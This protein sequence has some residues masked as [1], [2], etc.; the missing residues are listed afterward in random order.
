MTTLKQHLQRYLENYLELAKRRSQR[1]IRNY[2][3]YIER[4][5]KMS[6]LEDPAD[7]TMEAV[8]R[9]R[10]DLN[11]L[12][13]GHGRPLKASTQNYHLIAL[14][15]FL[16]YLSKND[17]KTLA[18][19]KIELARTTD[20]TVEFL[21]E[22]ELARL[23]AAPFAGAPAGEDGRP[24]IKQLRDKAVLEL[25]FSTGLRVS[26]LTGLK[27]DSVSLTQDEFSVRG[28]GDKVRVVF[29]SDAAKRALKAYLDRRGDVEPH[30]FV[31][32]DKAE[33]GRTESVSLTPRSVQRLIRHYAK[34]AGIL[35]RITPHTMRHTFATDL[36]RNGADIRSV[37]TML[38]HSSLTTT[39]IY[40]HVTDAHLREVFKEFHGKKK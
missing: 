11:R 13:D 28:K 12:K 23:L 3:F 39:Q 18:P 15:S 29:L 27:R 6:G 16:K 33:K 20:R 14:R 5:L 31:A 17:V 40:T 19:E 32:L 4:F 25:L 38:G 35:K 1:T 7:V 21:T 36:L 2:A 10:L 24:A 37:Q 22:A 30:L 9:F 8:D 34:A 26:E